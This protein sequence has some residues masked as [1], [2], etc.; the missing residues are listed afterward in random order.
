MIMVYENPTFCLNYLS[1]NRYSSKFN[2]VNTYQTYTSLCFM[3]E[4]ISHLLK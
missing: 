1:A 2:E 3:K 4:F